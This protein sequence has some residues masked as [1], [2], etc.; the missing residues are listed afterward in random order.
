MTA[1]A[2]ARAIFRRRTWPRWTDVIVFACAA[3]LFYGVLAIGRTWFGPFTPVTKI[4]RS[5][6]A[7]PFYAAYSLVRIVVAYFLSLFFAVL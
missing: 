3:A 7:L 6:R 4:S 1:T 2:I 5:P